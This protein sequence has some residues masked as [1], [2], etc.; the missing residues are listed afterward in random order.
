MHGGNLASALGHHE[1][2][3]AGGG[4]KEGGWL[5]REEPDVRLR[6]DGRRWVAW[7][8]QLSPLR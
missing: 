8:A 1:L 5:Q 2:V 3:R 4:G 7:G 6:R